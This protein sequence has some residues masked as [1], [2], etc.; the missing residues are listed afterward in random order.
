MALVSAKELLAAIEQ[1]QPLQSLRPGHK[2]VI[3]PKSISV[4]RLLEELKRAKA[5]MHW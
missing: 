2:P 3:V 5:D 4:F 1:Q